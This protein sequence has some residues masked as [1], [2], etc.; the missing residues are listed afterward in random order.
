MT[1]FSAFPGMTKC[2]AR[3]ASPIDIAR[4]NRLDQNQPAARLARKPK[5]IGARTASCVP[6]R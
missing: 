1:V 2:S 5:R 4:N 6:Q 3:S